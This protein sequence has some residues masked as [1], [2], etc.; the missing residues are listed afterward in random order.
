MLD[1]ARHTSSIVSLLYLSSVFA[2]AQAD[3]IE[4]RDLS[5]PQEL[6]GGWEYQ[7]CYV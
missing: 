7:G 1:M 6:D 4:K 5:A 3:F 2:P